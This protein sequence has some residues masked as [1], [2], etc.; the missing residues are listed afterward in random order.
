MNL[1]NTATLEQ[2]LN[3][4]DASNYRLVINDGMIKKLIKEVD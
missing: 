2:L 1:F 4:L 3:I